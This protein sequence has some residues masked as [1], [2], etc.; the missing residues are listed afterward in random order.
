MTA[1]VIIVG[2]TVIGFYWR[3]DYFD[4]ESPKFSEDGRTLSFAFPA[5][6]AVLKRTG[7]RTAKIAVT[8]KG[9]ST[10]LDLHRD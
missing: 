1:Q 3:N 5:G 4:A 10:D 8:E 2:A 7:E 9:R 6:T